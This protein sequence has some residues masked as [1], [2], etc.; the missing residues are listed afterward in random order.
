MELNMELSIAM[1]DCQKVSMFVVKS[2]S[3][4]KISNSDQEKSK[5]THIY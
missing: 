2:V 1:F 5:T 3:F 4:S